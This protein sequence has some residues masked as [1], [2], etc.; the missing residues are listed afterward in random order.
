LTIGFV[1]QKPTLPDLSFE[2]I[3]WQYDVEFVAGVDEAGRGALAGPVA[4]AVVILPNL[5]DL[6]E[7]LIGVRDSKQMTPKAR[8]Y[9]ADQIR[10]L[11]IS[12]GVGYAS[13][14]EIDQIGILP[15]TK[16]A[17]RRSLEQL[18]ITPQHL[19]VDYV[20]CS[21]IE[22]PQTSLIKGDARSL[23]IAA[24]SVLAKTERDALFLQLDQQYPG[25]GLAQNKGYGTQTHR[26]AIA[27]MGKSNIHRK[28]FLLKFEKDEH[29][30]KVS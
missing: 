29:D 14:L 11:A 24:A 28:R 26:D 21:E 22:I 2:G 18:S 9:W 13:N 19:L 10:L 4:A 12:F 27:L 20:K 17:I 3:L 25:Y 30:L 5:P 7:K 16:L 15:A 6:H 1:Q 8:Q 23:S